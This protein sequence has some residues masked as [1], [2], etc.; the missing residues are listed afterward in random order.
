MGKVPKTGGAKSKKGNG[1]RLV[2]MCAYT[3]YPIVWL[4]C[5]NVFRMRIEENDVSDD[6]DLVWTDH[7][8]P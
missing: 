3:I 6:F 8:L 1:P 5:K 4:T 7:A 2:V